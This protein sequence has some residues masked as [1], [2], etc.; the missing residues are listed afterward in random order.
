MI[1]LEVRDTILQILS[2][3]SPEILNK[4][5]GVLYS[6]YRTVREGDFFIMGLNPGGSPEDMSDCTIKQDIERICS[7]ERE[8]RWWNEYLDERWD[9]KEPGTDKLQLHIRHFIRGLLGDEDM[10]RKICASNLCFIRTRNEDDL[11]FKYSSLFKCFDFCWPVNEWLLA[12]VKPKILIVF[13]KP[14]C[15]YIKLKFKVSGSEKVFD[16]KWDKWKIR[17]AKAPLNGITGKE[18]FLLNIPHLSRYTFEGRED[19]IR[20]IKEELNL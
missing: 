5:G 2:E 13:S 18:T 7:R 9:N 20:K 4:S 3:R 15:D 16:A 17:I 8:N 10:L 11:N 14:A 19:L 6:S 1:C 12:K